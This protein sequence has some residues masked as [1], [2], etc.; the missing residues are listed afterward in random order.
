[1][2]HNKKSFVSFAIAA[3][4]LAGMLSLVGFASED[5]MGPQLQLAAQAQGFD[6]LAYTVFGQHDAGQQQI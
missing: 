2:S 5:L 3:V 6:A 1:M 4:S